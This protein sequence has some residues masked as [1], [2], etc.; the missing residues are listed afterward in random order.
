[1][2]HAGAVRPA[3]AAMPGRGL[4]WFGS[5]LPRL[6]LIRG[7]AGAASG[8]PLA[9]AEHRPVPSPCPPAERVRGGEWVGATSKP[10]TDVVAIGIGGSYLGPLFVH[11]AMQFD[12]PCKELARGRCGVVTGLRRGRRSGRW[13][14]QV[15]AA[16]FLAASL[17]P[18]LCPHRDN[19]CRRLL[20][21]LRASDAATRQAPA[22]P[23][24]CGSR[25]CG[26][27]AQR[28]QPW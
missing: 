9:P 8:L 6:D 3:G 5:G 12:E 15:D 16:G 20:C 2:A 28:P 26:Q 10:L 21:R 14:W 11:T 19:N 25:G 24:E 7:Q 4:V 1:M 17:D 13:Q 22:V 27:G 23:G 18:A